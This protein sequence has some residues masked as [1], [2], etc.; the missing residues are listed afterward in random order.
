MFASIVDLYRYPFIQNALI[1]GVCVAVASAVSGYFLVG[2]GFTFAGHA[3]PNIGFAGAAGAVLFGVRPVYGLFAL[4][5]LAAVTMAFAGRDVRERDVSIGVIMTFGLGLGL[6]FLSLYSGYAQQVYSILF[7]TILGITRQDTLLT[8]LSSMGVVGVLLFLFRPLLFSTVDPVTAAARGVPLLFLSVIF[9]VTV[10]VTVSLAVQVV[11]AMLVFTLLVGPSATA[12]R[13][14]GR[15]VHAILLS[16]FLGVSYVFIGITLAGLS[17]N[18][19]VSFFIAAISFLVY[20][21]VRI[22]TGRPH[23]SIRYAKVH[24]S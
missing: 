12:T 24:D 19:P 15:P 17:G 11:G 5:I 14:T 6:M 13:I 4:T 21:P 23:A 20:L 9:L 1:S 16:S 22:V 3:L 18:W 8:A 10:A 2:R 7:G